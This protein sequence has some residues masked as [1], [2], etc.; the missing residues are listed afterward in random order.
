L[1]AWDKSELKKHVA[2]QTGY[3]PRHVRR[4]LNVVAA[5]MEVQ[6]AH[7]R[8]KLKFE[9][10]D[11][12][13]ALNKDVQATIAAEIRGGADPATVVTNYLPKPKSKPVDVSAEFGKLVAAISVGMD[14]IAGHEN[15]IDRGA[16][17]MVKDIDILK[18]FAALS[19]LVQGALKKRHLG[20]I[21][22]VESFWAKFGG[23]RE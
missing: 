17:E 15:E 3:D 10:A 20:A 13:H 6:L 19:R 4:Y 18:K 7:S 5:P 22:A 14:A 21:R 2:A 1:C 23:E 16:D 12:V 8:G 9:F 11:K